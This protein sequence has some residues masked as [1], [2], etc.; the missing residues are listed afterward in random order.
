[1]TQFRT[2]R[3]HFL[4]TSAAAAA[5]A[6][7]S[8]ASLAAPA[9]PHA[10]KPLLMKLGCQTAPTDDTHLKYL[11]RYGVRN[12]C[13]YPVI[14]DGR[15]YATVEE[16]HRM[17]D[18][19]SANGIQVDMTTPPF[20]ASISV[21]EDQHAS[22]M[23]GQSP[24][25]DR[26][27]EDLQTLIRNCATAGIP[28]IKYNLQLVGD[29][30]IA[31]TPGRGDTTYSTW[32][33]SEAKPKTPLTRAGAVNADTAWERITYFLDRV[34]PVASEYRIR[35]ALHPDDPSVPSPGYQ[36]VERVLGTVDGMKRFI[37]IQENPYHGL[38]FCQGTVSEML[39]HPGTEIFDVIR[40]FGTRD[41]IFNV[42][43]RNIRG[44]RDDFVETYP[45]DGD[46]DFVK[47]LQVYKEVGYKYMLMPDHVPQAA[48]DHAGLQSFAYDYGY[49]RGLLQSAAE[50]S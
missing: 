39:A 40:Y 4:S 17:Q 48:N 24:Q 46:V 22:I 13:G 42:H 41:K 12:I 49:I 27:I 35:M 18:L 7:S 20:L 30:R 44:H 14:A 6:L 5:C 43:F 33:L 34:I 36:G 1:M 21:D 16:L 9:A 37:T 19:A 2:S 45:D 15:L 8:G 25:R 29:L 38:N 50:L 11:A 47:A 31:R 10:K 26:D 3:R 23:L 32:K 28:A